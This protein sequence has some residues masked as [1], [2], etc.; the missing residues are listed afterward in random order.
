[1]ARPEPLSFQNHG[2]LR[3]KPMPA[4]TSHFVQVFDS[5]FTSVATR[6]PILFTKNNATGGFYVGAVFGFKPGERLADVGDVGGYRPL[7]EQCD[8]F[9]LQGGHVAIDR[10]HPRFDEADGDALFDEAGEPTAALRQMQRLLGSVHAGLQTTH[11]FVDALRS[12]NLIELIDVALNFE[13]GE[14]LTLQG[15]YTV[16]LDRLRDLDDAGTLALCRAGHLQLA[17]AM[18]GSLK[19]IERLARVRNSRARIAR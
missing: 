16:S 7:V 9:L 14:R 10:D 18:A 12:R 15:L 13:D 6:C 19:Q 1:M 3:M 11:A 2:R 5:E 17:H 4:G 8:G